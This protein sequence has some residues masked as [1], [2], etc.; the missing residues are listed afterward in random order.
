MLVSYWSSLACLQLMLWLRE[1]P[2]LLYRQAQGTNINLSCDTPKPRAC[3]LHFNNAI[4]PCHK[5]NL[6][7]AL[8]SRGH[9]MIF[10]YHTYY[11]LQNSN[12]IEITVSN[13]T[14]S[15]FKK[16]SRGPLP[17]QLRGRIP[18]NSSMDIDFLSQPLIQMYGMSAGIRSHAHDFHTSS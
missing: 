13:K 4:I 5:Y 10:L 6:A 14:W 2:P 15:K 12:S 1:Y 17:D 16:K 7:S 3:V 18:S 11:Q 9:I 8:C